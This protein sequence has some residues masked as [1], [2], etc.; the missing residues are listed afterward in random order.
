M[1]YC[2]V[3]VSA[4]P[5]NQQLVTLHERRGAGGASS[6]WRRSTRPAPS[7]R[8]RARSRASGAASAVVAVDAPSGPAARP[9]RRRA[10]RCAPSSACPTGATSACG[11]ATRCCSAAGCRCTR[12][13]RAGAGA[14]AAWEEW[15]DVGFELFAALARPRAATGPSARTTRRRPRRRRAALRFGRAVRDLPATRSSARC[16]ATGRRRSARRGACSSGSPRCELQGRRRRRRRALAPHARRARRLRGRLRRLRA[17]RR[18]RDSGSASRDE[19]VIVLPVAGLPDRYEQAPAAGPV[20]AGLATAHLHWSVV[21]KTRSGRTAQSRYT[22]TA[23]ARARAKQRAFCV[24]ALPEGDDLAELKELL[25]TAGVAVVGELVQHR[26]QPHP[27][28][29]LGPGQGRGAQGAAQGGGRERRRL[30][31][32]AHARARSATSRR[33]SACRWSTA[34]R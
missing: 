13:R 34:R 15:I 9:A 32:R 2:G 16:S 22:P 7:S 19:G 10:R 6:S 31:R 5:A 1:R 14:A 24:G 8:S 12:C 28:L 33:S 30:R 21:E 11:C 27:N 17:G 4:K 29:Y 23:A 25:R 20:G 26:E 3:D 18:A